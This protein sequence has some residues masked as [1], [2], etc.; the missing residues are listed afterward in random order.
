MNTNFET[1]INVRMNPITQDSQFRISYE[2]VPGKNHKK[3]IPQFRSSDSDDWK[4]LSYFK[5][6]TQE[7][8][9]AQFSNWRKAKRFFR[10]ILI[11]YNI[12][13][14]DEFKV[15]ETN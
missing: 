7:T 1:N 10:K 11:G 6:D 12:N 2:T 9:I 8:L 14:P 13:I 4:S 15:I 5:E 3:Y